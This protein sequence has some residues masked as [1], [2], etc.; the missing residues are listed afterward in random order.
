[1][2]ERMTTKAAQTSDG[3]GK[4]CGYRA[5][6][7]DFDNTIARLEPVVGWAAGR[8]ELEPWMRAQGVPEHLFVEV[9]RGNLP[10]YDAA[11]T[12]MLANATNRNDAANFT[13]DQVYSILRGASEI[14]ETYE[15]AGVDQAEPLAGAIDFVRELSNRGAKLAIVTSN[16]T[17][18]VKLW[19]EQ[20][21]ILDSFAAFVGRDSGL[22]L[23][24]APDMV[25]RALS[26]LKIDAADAAFV[27]D[28]EADLRA[29][30]AMHVNFFAVAHNDAA[31]EKLARA[32]V[33]LVFASPSELALHLGLEITTPTAAI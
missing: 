4:V 32:G 13:V 14:I 7:F 10:L 3:S 6:L 27:G 8:R 1:M 24:P 31:R 30:Q 5:W 16:S 11:R 26:L 12:Q 25:E 33:H 2:P 9:P 29:A 20:H 28:S 15:L 23:K 18:T 17:R 21:Q 19:M 22:G